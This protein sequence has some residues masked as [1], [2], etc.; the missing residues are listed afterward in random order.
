VWISEFDV[1]NSIFLITNSASDNMYWDCNGS[2]P[3]LL[4]NPRHE[5]LLQWICNKSNGPFLKF[6]YIISIRRISPKNG[7]KVLIFRKSLQRYTQLLLQSLWE[8]AVWLCVITRII[9][10]MSCN[11]LHIFYSFTKNMLLKQRILQCSEVGKASTVSLVGF[12]LIRWARKM[13]GQCIV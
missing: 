5:V 7:S 6:E 11:T 12:S 2:I 13:R 4:N 10:L 9:E 8:S 3:S 1:N